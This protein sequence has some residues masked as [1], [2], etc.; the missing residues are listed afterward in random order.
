MDTNIVYVGMVGD[1]IHV[2]HINIL[3]R[4]RQLG[5]VIVGV[6]TD[7]AVAEYK[8]TPL[9]KFPDRVRVIESLAGVQ[10]V[11]AQQTLSY[12]QNLLQLRPRYVVHG[13]DWRYGEKVSVARREVIDTLSQWGGELVE[14]P[15]TPGVSST[16]IHQALE[17]QGILARIRQPRLRHLLE[18]KTCIRIIE[19]HSAL[20]AL[21]AHRTRHEARTFDALWQSS[22]TDASLRAK[23]DVEIV[24]HGARLATI[25]EIFDAVPLPLIYDGDTGGLPEKIFHVARS[26]DR[27]GVSAI[28]LE[29]KVGAKRKS[30]L[31]TGVEQHQ[32]S[33]GAFCERIDAVKRATTYG[34]MMFIARIE[35]F[36]L[37]AG[38]ADAL[39][40]A[41]AYIQAGSD[42]VLIH[43]IAKTADEVLSFS[44][45]MRRNE[46]KIPIFVVPTTYGTTHENVLA[47]AGINAVIYANHLLRAAY[48]RMVQT[49]LHILREG[50]SDDEEMRGFLSPTEDILALIPTVK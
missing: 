17:E 44:R 48:P 27:A 12:R 26:L 40:R 21:I 39:M 31:G 7:D 10:R 37:G 5:A 34:N 29:D 25:N 35:S 43:S 38:L 3:T 22:F 19:A 15:Y 45:A 32:V 49:A 28:C 24:D 50:R 4:A 30:L 36:V 33:I 13:D 11:V 2:G 9:M 47:E 20:A 14:V 16:L 6:L 18:A 23:P 46:V 8:R 41:E 1:I 42:A